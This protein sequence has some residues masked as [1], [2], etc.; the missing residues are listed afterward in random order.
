MRANGKFSD[1]SLEW[2]HSVSTDHAM[3]QS[4]AVDLGVTHEPP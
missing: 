1:T 3:S 2:L 4:N